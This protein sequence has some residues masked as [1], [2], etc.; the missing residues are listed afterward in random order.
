VQEDQ[1]DIADAAY[2]V[3]EAARAILS[4][5]G[6]RDADGDWQPLPQ[7]SLSED[8]R[9]RI[10]PWLFEPWAELHAAVTRWDVE[11][12]PRTCV[13]RL[14]QIERAA[15]ALLAELDSGAWPRGALLELRDALDVGAATGP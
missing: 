15:R 13:E 8:E 4:V 2:R 5:L 7:P 11:I 12:A 9:R 3:I 14:G 6:Q 1:Y 10:K